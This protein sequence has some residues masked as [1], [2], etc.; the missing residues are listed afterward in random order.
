[1][2]GS[3]HHLVALEAKSA[4]FKDVLEPLIGVGVDKPS[5]PTSGAIPLSAE[6]LPVSSQKKR[7][8]VAE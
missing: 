6:V 4:I 8:R 2:Q 3:S 7:K 1:M 5:Q